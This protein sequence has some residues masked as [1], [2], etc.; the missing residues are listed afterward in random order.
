MLIQAAFVPWMK[1]EKGEGDLPAPSGNFVDV[2]DSER[3]LAFFA[4]WPRAA[5]P[6]LTILWLTCSAA[7]AHILALTKEEAGGERFLTSNGPMSGNDYVMVSSIVSCFE[8]ILMAGST[9][10]RPRHQE[11]AQ[12][13][14]LCS[15]EN[16]CGYRP[17]G[18]VEAYS[19][20][21]PQ[22]QAYR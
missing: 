21:R 2:R 16:Q 18:R 7:L 12:G 8:P 9:Q 10:V 22:V 17:R 15:R 4:L 6:S 13:R 11:R 19:G 1:G 14:C 3:N 5:L 20:S